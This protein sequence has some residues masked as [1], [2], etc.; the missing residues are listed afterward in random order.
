MLISLDVGILP[1]WCVLSTLYVLIILVH[2]L[3]DYFCSILYH[4]SLDMLKLMDR[5]SGYNIMPLQNRLLV[6][7][8]VDCSMTFFFLSF[9]LSFF[10]SLLLSFFLST[11]CFIR[12]SFITYKWIS[13]FMAIPLAEIT[14]PVICIM[15]RGIAGSQ[16]TLCGEWLHGCKHWD[17]NLQA[18]TSWF[19]WCSFFLSFVFLSASCFLTIST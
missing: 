14:L 3:F 8:F 18:C 9:L 13:G 11:F 15:T 16:V 4:I 10:L 2:L 19:H 6:T 5:P 12:D 17:L 1:P 7:S